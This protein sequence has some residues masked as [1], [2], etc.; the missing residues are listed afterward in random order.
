MLDSINII[1]FDASKLEIINFLNIEKIL[2]IKKM[3]L[4]KLM[5][6]RV[7]HKF[8]NYLDFNNNENPTVKTLLCNWRGVRGKLLALKKK[9]SKLMRQTS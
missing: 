5:G 6:Q 7:N 1:L 3:L 4:N 9:G 8:R 2:K